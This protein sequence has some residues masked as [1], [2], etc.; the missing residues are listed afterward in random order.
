M[1][2]SSKWSRPRELLIDRE[3]EGTTIIRNVI[4]YRPET[5]S[6]KRILEYSP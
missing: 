2:S 1:P 6:H 4:K 3:E 5:M